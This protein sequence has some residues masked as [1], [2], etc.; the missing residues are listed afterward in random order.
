MSEFCDMDAKKCSP[1]KAVGEQCDRK[2]ACETYI[3]VDSQCSDIPIMNVPPTFS[4]TLP[5]GEACNAEI[6]YPVD[7]KQQV[8]GSCK[9][10]GCPDEKQF[11]CEDER[12]KIR[13][14]SWCYPGNDLMPCI[15]VCERSSTCVKMKILRGQFMHSSIDAN[16]MPENYENRLNFYVNEIQMNNPIKFQMYFTDLLRLIR[17]RNSV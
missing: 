16:S 17:I 3:C 5:S 10:N 1:R 9:P 2:N 14:K 15:N 11:K 13:N 8:L 6:N 12:C 4:A 7:D